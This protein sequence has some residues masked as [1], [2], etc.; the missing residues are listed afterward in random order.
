MCLI[1]GTYMK[2]FKKVLALLAC[3]VLLGGGLLSCSSDGDD[4]SDGNGLP[5]VDTASPSATLSVVDA[6]K[7]T[8][9]D[10][11]DSTTFEVAVTLTNVSFKGPIVSTADLSSLVTFEPATVFTVKSINATADVADGATSATL[12][13][14]GKVLKAGDVTVKLAAG[15]LSSN[16]ALSAGGKLTFAVTNAG[17]STSSFFTWNAETQFATATDN[18]TVS[19]STAYGEVT[20]SPEIEYL[21][22]DSSSNPVNAL[23]I[24]A[25]NFPTSWS[26]PSTEKILSFKAPAGTKKI[27]IKAS[28]G[29][30]SSES[31]ITLTDGTNALISEKIPT[32]SGS[33][34]TGATYNDYAK[35]FDAALETETTFYVTNLKSGE[36]PFNPATA[37]GGLLIK[38]IKVEGDP[39]VL[40]SI[41]IA[42]QPDKLV[43]AVGDAALDTEGMKVKGTYSDGT[44]H[45]VNGWTTSGFD[46][47]TAGEKTIT[48]SY[49]EGEVTKTAEFKV[50]VK[51]KAIAS[52]AIKT[53]PTKKEYV[54]GDKIDLTGLELTI[55]YDDQSASTVAYSASNASDF[56]TDFDSSAAAESKEVT[57]TY[58][59]KTAKFSV[60]IAEA[61][62][63]AKFDAKELYVN[64]DGTVATADVN[65]QASKK[66]NDGTWELVI[67]S[68]KK[69]QVKAGEFATYDYNAETNA[70]HKW[71]NRLSFNKQAEGNVAL[72]LKVGVAKQVILRVDGGS[73]KDLP[74]ASGESNFT[75]KGAGDAIVWKPAVSLVT[76]YVTVTGDDEGFVTITSSDTTV[77]ANIYGITVVAEA[78]DTSTVVLPTKLTTDAVY[79]KPAISGNAAEY[80]Q[81]DTITATATVA[82]PTKSTSTVV[83]ANGTLGAKTEGTEAVDLTKI[84]WT[85]KGSAEDAQAITIGNGANLSF[86]TTQAA[87]DTYTVTAAY[88]I[89]EGEAAVSYTSDPVTAQ[90][91]AAGATYFD[92][93]FYDGETELIALKV[94]VASGDKVTKPVD[95]AKDG[96][97][98]AGWY[99]DAG[100]TTEFDFANTTISAETKIYAKWTESGEPTVIYKW[101]TDG[102]TTPTNN[103]VVTFTGIG[104]SWDT[105]NRT[106]GDVSYK[107]GLKTGGKTSATRSVKIVIPTGKTGSIYAVGCANSGSGVNFS[108]GTAASSETPTTGAVNSTSTSDLKAI[109][110]ESLAAGT[111][112]LN[113]DNSA[114][115]YELDVSVN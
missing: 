76:T 43:Y 7:L 36:S 51:E 5:P 50:T 70:G 100:L 69:A 115:L 20:L 89:G 56:T 12:S 34:L 83:Y 14:K 78:V 8:V 25:R 87:A 85:A 93:K 104:T 102:A 61:T 95:P 114:R 41:E 49:T 17:G 65:V 11:E 42:I 64:A 107:G 3:S 59:E 88:T 16:E 99:T 111:Y 105:S 68:G 28:S 73:V 53:E 22:V 79:N 48:V 82:D 4:G 24:K 21:K 66:S 47:A 71:T 96:F 109:T 72:K 86:D 33:G 57:V 23:R 54:T 75:F 45:K 98:F 74:A 101:V 40:E 110:G 18:V 19:S 80:T 10:A 37:G 92:V 15:A 38:S 46:S 113:F 112:Y 94:S 106:L 67:A 90:I 52:I 63:F 77:G 31:N 55:T 91:K 6:A 103:D 9:E 13:V 108:I 30:T 60:K 32:I 39:A 27:T 1:G 97:T 29:S 58:K 35:S 26:S 84:V 2:K 81:G 44:S 62:L